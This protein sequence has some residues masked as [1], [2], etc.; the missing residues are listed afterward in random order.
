MECSLL[1]RDIF[2]IVWISFYSCKFLSFF[3]QLCSSALCLTLWLLEMQPITT[4]SNICWEPAKYQIGESCCLGRIT[5]TKGQQA[6]CPTTSKHSVKKQFMSFPKTTI[7]AWELT[8]HQKQYNYCKRHWLATM[9]ADLS[10]ALWFTAATWWLQHKPAESVWLKHLDHLTHSCLWC[11]SGGSSQDLF[12]QS[13]LTR[14]SPF[15]VHTETRKDTK[16][17]WVQEHTGTELTQRNN[18]GGCYLIC[19]CLVASANRSNKTNANYE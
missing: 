3:V 19:I 5:H 4:Q 8:S 10:G 13:T 7:N 6:E 18:H 16:L 12:W 15:T 9:L 1:M 14:S 11:W 2:T 17:W